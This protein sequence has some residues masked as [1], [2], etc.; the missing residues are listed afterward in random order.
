M[1]ARKLALRAAT[2]ILA[3]V[4]RSYRHPPSASTTASLA[5]A[6]LVA[7]GILS[8]G[9]SG[10]PP[11]APVVATL[12]TSTMPVAPEPQVLPPEHWYFEWLSQDGKRALLRRL[13]GTSRSRFH[14]RVVDVDSGATVAEE[15]LDALARVPFETIGHDPA[16]LPK[17]DAMLETAEVGDDLLRG[18]KVVGSFPLG[19]TTRFSASPS[20]SAIAFNAGDW[21]YVADKSGHVRKRIAEEASYDPRFTPDGKNLLFRRLTGNVDHVFARYELFVVPAD[22]SGPARKLEGTAG[23]RDRF[24]VADGGATAITIASR[25][26]QIK[27][28]VLGVGLKAPFA[29]KRVACLDGGELLVDTV[30][31]PKGK[32]VAITTQRRLDGAGAGAASGANVAR[33]KDGLRQLAWRLR[34]VSIAT[35]KVVLDESQEAGLGI[36]AVSDAGLLVQSGPRGVVLTDVPK[37]K[38]RALEQPFDIG[39]RGY[40]RGASELVFVQGRDVGVVDLAKMS[41]TDEPSR[42]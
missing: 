18:A 20:G 36:R 1:P 2:C 12:P 10:P 11:K 40:F 21:L 16:E 28:C 33:A 22:L 35:G 26:P 19:S 41:A 3:R 13:D 31:S 39:Y 4:R 7:L 5:A 34:V 29:V 27:T 30:F 14:A 32:F 17:L 42:S 6:S 37:K 8:G 24:V 23:A 9:C 38:R 25:E 15:K